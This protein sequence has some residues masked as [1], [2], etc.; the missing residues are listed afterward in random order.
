MSKPNRFFGLSL[1]TRDLED[2][3]IEKYDFPEDTKIV[4]WEMPTNQAG[5]AIRISSKEFPI[6]NDFVLL[7]TARLREGYKWEASTPEK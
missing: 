7:N 1:S 4:H 3:L 6:V 2:Y 5:W